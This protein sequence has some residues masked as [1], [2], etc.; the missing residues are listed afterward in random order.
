M[1]FSEKTFANDIAV[2]YDFS[3]C[4]TNPGPIVAGRLPIANRVIEI[5]VLFFPKPLTSK[6]S[7]IRKIY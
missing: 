1:L 5:I 4:L 2:F 7:K 3:C 6:L